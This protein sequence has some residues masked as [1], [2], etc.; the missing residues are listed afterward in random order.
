MKL[1]TVLVLCCS[2]FSSSTS[3]LP[4]QD[5]DCDDPDVFKAVEIALRKYNADKTDGNQF[6]LYMVMEAK[7]TTG[8]GK[9]FF[10]KYRIRESSCA[11]G[12]DKLWQDC[13][14]RA[15]SEAESGECTAHVYIDKAE[16]INNVTQECKIVPVEGRV[17][18]SHAECLGCYHPI[19]GNSLQLLPILRYAIRVFNKETDQPSLFEVGEI[20]KA[21]R[22]VVAGWNYAIEYEVKE[23]NCSKDNFEDLS[24]ACKPIFGGRVALCEAKA[25]V[26]LQN[27]I[28][29]VAQR[30]KFPVV[31]TVSPP[32]S[33]C[34]GCPR[35]IPTNSTEL[36]EPL[37]ASL[38]KYN[39]DSNDDFYYKAEAITHATVQVV[40]GK[41]YNITFQIRKTNCSKS[42]VT[43]LNEDCQA[44]P[45]SK[46]LQ[47]TAQVYVVPWLKTIYPEVNCVMTVLQHWILQPGTYKSL[48]SAVTSSEPTQRGT[49]KPNMYSSQPF[50]SLKLRWRPASHSEITATSAKSAA[51]HG[52]LA[53]IL[54]P[55]ILPLFSLQIRS[56]L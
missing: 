39:E 30:C 14:Y 21:T 38:K 44:E 5:A 9:H 40:A 23:T 55:L 52:G 4:T 51:C 10:V 41:N 6:A 16:D 29:D 13:D 17:T 31:E 46:P 8:P 27:T 24:P 22:Q 47:C 19:P 3:P 43:Q 42:A 56:C 48:N 45:D 2:F 54:L 32:T 12:G 50:K 33:V 11:V 36:E 34:A 49:I 7:R 18:V 35:P 28:V 53:L 1:F 37:R 25:Y 26:D 20:I 15:S